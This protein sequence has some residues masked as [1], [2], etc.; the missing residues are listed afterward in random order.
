MA[1]VPEKRRASNVMLALK[2]VYEKHECYIH[3]QYNKIL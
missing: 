1:P 3:N 2:E